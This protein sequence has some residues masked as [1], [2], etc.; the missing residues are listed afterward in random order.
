MSFNQ[1]TALTAEVSKSMEKE[2]APRSSTLAWRIPGTGQ[3]G[4]LQLTGS[5]R[6]GHDW[7]DLACMHACIGEGNGNPLQC[8]CL[9]NPRDGAAWWAAIYGVAQNRTDCSDLAA[10]EIFSR[11]CGLIS[12]HFPAGGT[13]GIWMEPLLRKLCRNVGR[14]P[15]QVPNKWL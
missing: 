10:A 13:P 11:L 5:H 14:D 7:S 6:V 3:P 1:C 12:V 2:M 15:N 9:E 8:S 4:G